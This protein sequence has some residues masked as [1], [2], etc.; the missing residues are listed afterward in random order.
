MVF[1]PSTHMLNFQP[2]D[3]SPYSRHVQDA[4]TQLNR[5]QSSSASRKFCEDI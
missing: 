3:T 1:R 2:D 4:F 5:K